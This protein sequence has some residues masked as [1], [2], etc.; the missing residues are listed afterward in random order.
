MS[1]LKISSVRFWMLSG[2]AVLATLFAA[3]G[4]TAQEESE[5]FQRPADLALRPSGLGMRQAM[6]VAINNDPK[7]KLARARSDLDAGRTTEVQGLF[8]TAGGFSFSFERS[9]GALTNQAREFQ[10]NRRF[11]EEEI[12]RLFG[13]VIDDLERQLGSGEPGF[14]VC[15]GG[16]E[17]IIIEGLGNICISEK[18]KATAEYFLELLRNRGAENPA[19]A[20][21][22]RR[23][24]EQ[25]NNIVLSAIVPPLTINIGA[26]RNRLAD[27]G[28]LPEIEQRYEMRFELRLQKLFR[29]GVDFSSGLIVTGVEDNFKGKAPFAF[30]GGKNLPNVFE[31]FVGFSLDV[32]LGKGGGRTATTVAERA[33]ELRHRA[34]VLS[35]AHTVSASA[36]NAAIRYWELVAAQ[37]RLGLLESAVETEERLLAAAREL[38]DADEIPRTTLELIEARLASVRASAVQERQRAYVAKI[39]LAEGIG[40]AIENASEAPGA[41]DAFP[42]VLSREELESLDTARLL[43]VA[44]NSRGD[45]RAA[46]KLQQASAVLLESSQYD[47]RRQF[48]LSLIFGYSGLHETFDDQYYELSGFGEALTGDLVG[49][50][51]SLSLTTARPAGNRVARAQVEQ[52]LAASRQSEIAATDLERSLRIRAIEA[53]SSLSELAAEVE[54]REASA[55]FSQRTL[56]A[57][58][59]LFRAGE[60]SLI[61]AILTEEQNT[62][63]QVSVVNTKLAYASTLARVMFETGTLVTYREEDDGRKLII[64]SVFPEDALRAGP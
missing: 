22:V 64:E 60:L 29:N 37:D 41:A 23:Y 34:S 36:L 58:M 1:F 16:L 35:T 62:F 40:L 27:L 30:L 61:D 3:P 33:A 26:A 52:A 59:E 11:L 63:A 9:D 21:I 42:A 4:A 32:P 45:L 20:E 48:D 28:F 25:T 24:I 53:L 12:I 46:E 7:L 5:S 15:P 13:E 51:A 8:D 56:E 47:L 18:D 49:P 54:R 43:Q 17:E 2:C 55:G 6:L 38:V 31:S 57:T 19:I 39:A 10:I 44:R 14:V 50:T